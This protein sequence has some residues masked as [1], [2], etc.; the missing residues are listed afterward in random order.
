MST[1]GEFVTYPVGQGL[2]YAGKLNIDKIEKK[3][4]NFIYDCGSNHFGADGHLMKSITEYKTSFNL[5][6]VIDMLVI[7][8]L[9]R[10]HL[11]GLKEL[12]KET[13][14]KRIFLPYIK[15]LDIKLFSY[16]LK[17]LF[18]YKVISE[19]T[20]VILINGLVNG[21][22]KND[23]SLSLPSLEKLE[24]KASKFNLK[25]DLGGL[26]NSLKILEF[27]ETRFQLFDWLFDFYNYP[28]PKDEI[29]SIKS[30][31][32]EFIKRNKIK[33]FEDFI[34]CME[35]WIPFSKTVYLENIKKDNF[36]NDN[37]NL[38][39][40]LMHAPLQVLEYKEASAT[41]LTGDLDLN[42]EV[43]YKGFNSK[44]SYILEK[45]KVFFLPHHGSRKNWNE[46][47]VWSYCN[48]T[49]SIITSG[50]N[51]EHHP[52]FEVI[53]K[54]FLSKNDFLSITEKFDSYKYIIDTKN[55]N[56]SKSIGKKS[57]LK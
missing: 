23:D 49:L 39:L 35:F 2:F 45:L 11:S 51:Y 34:N 8:H 27:N 22:P 32:E 17:T 55:L 20:K 40:C 41:L 5:T 13:T 56:L 28:L 16:V 36:M 21:N 18:Y 15:N 14:I 12:A 43:I 10:D 25:L 30:S 4:F 6:K 26:E 1:K 50:S 48:N 3:E 52:D 47:L 44:Y 54:I 29:L 46:K 37:N 24:S 31:F 7:S 9:D 57:S 42:K 33:K 19:E 53:S 38:S